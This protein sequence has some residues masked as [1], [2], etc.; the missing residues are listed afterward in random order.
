MARTHAH[1]PELDRRTRTRLAARAV[2]ALAALA[3]AFLAAC[4]DRVADRGTYVATIAGQRF[5]LT[6]SASD[7]TRQRGLGGV[8]DIP[9]DGGMIFVFPDC[10]M[11][12]FWMKDCVTDMDI[13]YLDALGYVTAT[14]TMRM[15]P[16]R[17]PGEDPLAYE[18]RL[19]RYS[20][21]MPSQFVIE[22]RK[23][24]VAELGLGTQQKIE[25]DREALTAAAR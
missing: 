1:G 4:D 13:V 5:S 17:R 24:R 7:A 8:A 18:A 16:P 20:S 12:G 3:A 6:V 19:P 11:R 15:E 22:L 25:L 14:H 23:G 9:A 10:R 21:V 2:T